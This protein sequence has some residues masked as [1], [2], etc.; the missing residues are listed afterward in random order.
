MNVIEVVDVPQGASEDEARELLNKPCE[1]NRYMLIQ[2]LPLPGG[3]IRAFYRLVA[4]AYDKKPGE[5]HK[6]GGNQA[7]LDGND[8]AAR[9]II[10][11]N[12][13]LTIPALIRLLAESDIKRGKTWV[14]EARIAI[15]GNGAKL[16]Q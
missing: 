3:G 14:C 1:V 11:A 2:V 13:T 4:R 12:G 8:D 15:R 5:R 16:T 6:L 10:G 7:K 9:A